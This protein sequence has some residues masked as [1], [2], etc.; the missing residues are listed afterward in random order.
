[1]FDSITNENIRSSLRALDSSNEARIDLI[2]RKLRF[3]SYKNNK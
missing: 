2:Q 3:N 1:M